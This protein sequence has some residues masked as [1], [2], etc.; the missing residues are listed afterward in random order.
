MA[1]IHTPTQ[2][3]V[4]KK[5]R[6]L[7]IVFSDGKT[8]QLPCELLRVLA[9]SAEVKNSD[10]PVHGKINVN[11]NNIEPQGDYGIR[12]YFDDGYN[13]GI[14]SWESLYDMGLNQQQ[15]WQTY[16][17]RLNQHGLQRGESD[18]KTQGN[19]TVLYFMDKILKITKTQ[20]EQITLDDRI[21]TVQD[22]LAFLRNRGVIWAREFADDKMLITVNKEFAEIFTVLED[23]DEV[24]FVPRAQ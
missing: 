16:L 8:F 5:S 23:G 12:I 22:L 11:I 9:K 13:T 3:N 1:F 18:K 19:I 15:Y 7:E 24:A 14:Y 6:L 20:E 4:H 21:K 2:I 17:D 10:I